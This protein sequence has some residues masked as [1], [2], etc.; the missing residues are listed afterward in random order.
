[1]LLGVYI[2]K[3]SKIICFTVAILS[4]LVSI[5]AF[6]A[7][8]EWDAELTIAS[9]NISYDNNLKFV[10]AVPKSAIEDTVTLTIDARGEIYS[11]TKTVASLAS[12]SINDPTVN[13]IECYAIISDF[14]IPLKDMAMECILTVASG[15]K[16]AEI[17]YSM[18]E[19]LYER[20]FG[21][22]VVLAEEG[23]PD[24]DRRSLYFS[25][26]AT[27]ADAERVLYNLN[28]DKSDDITTFV[29]EYFYSNITGTPK[30]YKAGDKVSITEFTSIYRYEESADGWT[31]KEVVLAP[32]EIEIDSHI[33]LSGKSCITDFEDDFGSYLTRKPA[34][35]TY[36]SCEVISENTPDSS[37]GNVLKVTQK[38]LSSSHNLL[39][40]LAPMYSKDDGNVYVFDFDANFTTPNVT[41]STRYLMS[42]DFGGATVHVNTY[43]SEVRINGTTDAHLTGYK[44][45]EWGS[46]RLVFE[47][48]ASRSAK[49]YV[50]AKS[51][52]SDELTL[53]HTAT[54]SG[55]GIST[56]G[57]SSI[58]ISCYNYGSS[59]TVPYTY[60][61]DNLSFIRTDDASSYV[62]FEWNSTDAMN[63]VTE[64]D[65]AWVDSLKSKF[66]TA[67]GVELTVSATAGAH[68]L[69]VGDTGCAASDVAYSLLEQYLASSEYDDSEGYVIYVENGS[70][71]VAYNSTVARVEAINNLLN[72]AAKTDLLTLNG[73][74]KSD[75]Y[76]LIERAE[77]S[78]AAMHQAQLD[79]IE[80]KLLG[81]G[82]TDA[83]VIRAELEQFFSYY[84]TNIITWLANLYDKDVGGFYFSKSAR[85]YSSYQTMRSHSRLR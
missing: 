17:S 54:L 74:I 33:L 16:T 82:R 61:L 83:S 84:D 3:K 22:E 2:V 23:T 66:K 20:L 8:A 15:G 9:K 1:M 80:R 24:A 42:I 62:P 4:L 50:Y 38:K 81:A 85:V 47:V 64:G 49:M 73:E 56:T 37:D 6:S 67:T 26:L 69:L 51:F 39:L 70:V 30:L 12:D 75:V 35:V 41:N 10:V 25:T 71:A 68:A 11:V 79:E 48:T 78:R 45:N 77:E 36:A 57:V 18:A 58:G 28:D 32:G 44:L 29:D 59:A 31:R 14:G 40:G 72:L 52:T 19:Y 34:G 63:L 43:K 13:G 46:Y 27:G 5:L 60:Y 55:S 7:S 65:G 53:L 21:D 76:S